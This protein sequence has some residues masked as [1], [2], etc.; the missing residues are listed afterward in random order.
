MAIIVATLMLAA[1]TQSQ[2]AK[3]RHCTS[4]VSGQYVSHS[5]AIKHPETTQ[6]SKR[7]RTR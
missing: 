6:C 4:S 3:V 1:A 2:A 5:Y 7:K